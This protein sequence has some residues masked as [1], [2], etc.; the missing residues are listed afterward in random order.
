MLYIIF[1]QNVSQKVAQ[2][3]EN[4]V[5]F[6][7]HIKELPIKNALALNMIDFGAL[8]RWMIAEFMS[9]INGEI[10]AIDVIKVKSLMVCT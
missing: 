8:L 2:K 1:F 9:K 4:Y 5:F 3:L 10:V 7:L 6:L